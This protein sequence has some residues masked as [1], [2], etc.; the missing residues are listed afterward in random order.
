M[1]IELVVYN[2]LQKQVYVFLGACLLMSTDLTSL[3]RKY[4]GHSLAGPRLLQVFR[5]MRRRFIAL[6]LQKCFVDCDVSGG[7]SSRLCCISLLPPR[8]RERA[9]VCAVHV[10]GHLGRGTNFKQPSAETYLTA[11]GTEMQRIHKSLRAL[12]IFVENHWVCIVYEPQKCHQ[13]LI[14]FLKCA[15]RPQALIHTHTHTHT[16]AHIHQG[17]CQVGKNRPLV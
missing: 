9:K 11:S 3:L 15:C 16:L 13:C 8:T 7:E 12:D 4:W 2:T 10:K 17:Q 1:P 6:T 5:R 14:N